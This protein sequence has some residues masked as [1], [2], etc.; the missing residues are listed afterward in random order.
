MRIFKIFSE[1]AHAYFW[2]AK[3]WT[4]TPYAYSTLSVLPWSS[5]SSQTF[6]SGF[7]RLSSVSR[8]GTF[9]RKFCAAPPK[10]N[11]KIKPDN[12]WFICLRWELLELCLCQLFIGIVQ[13]ALQLLGEVRFLVNIGYVIWGQIFLQILSDDF[14]MGIRVIDILIVPEQVAL[15]EVRPER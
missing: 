5:L 8:V 3:E 15:F 4:W 9:S 6:P 2:A 11:L 7:R 10:A 14:V 1:R 12:W 13:G